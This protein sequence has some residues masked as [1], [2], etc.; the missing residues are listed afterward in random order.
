MLRNRRLLVISLSL[1][2]V[3]VLSAALVLNAQA[4]PV[5]QSDPDSP[6]VPVNFYLYAAK[7]VCGL[8]GTVALNPPQEPP[9][10]PGNYATSINVVNPLPSNFNNSGTIR[11]RKIAVISYPEPTYTDHASS[12]LKYISVNPLRSF[13]IDCADIF[14]S[15]FPTPPV[16]GW[17]SFIEGYVVLYAE[18]PLRVTAVYTSE[19]PAAIGSYDPDIDVEDVPGINVTVGTVAAGVSLEEL[20][21]NAAGQ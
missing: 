6:Q 19:A 7:F 15:I 13:Y 11:V 21:R 10:K 20:E 16:G 3:L 14:G 9:V 4:R 12:A 18:K 1:I 8:Q 5:S 17:P 2:A